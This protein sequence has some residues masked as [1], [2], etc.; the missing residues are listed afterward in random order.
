MKTSTMLQVALMMVMLVS[1]CGVGDSSS[2]NLADQKAHRFWAA[3]SGTEPSNQSMF[4]RLRETDQEKGTWEV[5]INNLN[6]GAGEPELYIGLTAIG[7]DRLHV[8]IVFG[9]DSKKPIGKIQIPF[10]FRTQIARGT[11]VL[12]GGAPQ[13][14]ECRPNGIRPRGGVSN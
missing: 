5:L 14:I 9:K 12:N 1:G 10:T 11:L 7:N 13:S 8:G 3:C 4:V 6:G 2:A